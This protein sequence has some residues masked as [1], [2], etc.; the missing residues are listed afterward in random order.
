MSDQVLNTAL[1]QL[2]NSESAVS[3]ARRIIKVMSEA[4]HD[5][6]KQRAE[7]AQL[8]MQRDKTMTAL[9]NNGATLPEAR[10]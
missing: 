8:E 5:V 7:L 1:L 3:D 4:G 6:T 2:H 10:P 9:K